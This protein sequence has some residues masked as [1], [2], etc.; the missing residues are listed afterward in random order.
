MP[1][2]KAIARPEGKNILFAGASLLLAVLVAARPATI[3][4]ERYIPGLGSGQ[5]REIEQQLAQVRSARERMEKQRAFLSAKQADLKDEIRALGPDKESVLA[6]PDAGQKLAQLEKTSEL[7]TE[8]AAKVAQLDDAI[9]R[10]ELRLDELRT[11]GTD[12]D[13]LAGDH[14]LEALLNAVENATPP[15]DLPP[16]EAYLK[17]AELEQLYESEF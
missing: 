17:Q 7:L 16:A 4:A 6:H 2:A 3:L 15:E 5:E 9:A 14:E 1:A 12:A 13:A 8:R 11:L 10:L